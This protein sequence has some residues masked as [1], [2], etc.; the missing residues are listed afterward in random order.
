M[1]PIYNIPSQMSFSS[2][3]LA[4]PYWL[5]NTL[6]NHCTLYKDCR[7][8]ILISFTEA[9]LLLKQCHLRDWRSQSFLCGFWLC[10]HAHRFFFRILMILF[11]HCKWWNSYNLCKHLRN[12]VLK[13]F[14]DSFLSNVVS[15]RTSLLTKD[16]VYL[17]W[18]FYSYV[19]LEYLLFLKI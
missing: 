7:D 17:R 1:L 10:F 6:A 14:A 11:V 15:L 18:F 19:W 4:A 9:C 3:K 12:V 8:N 5:W 16:Q 2:E 13:Q